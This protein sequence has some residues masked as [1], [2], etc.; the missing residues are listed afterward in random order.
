MDINVIRGL[1]TIFALFAFLCV[2]GWAYSSHRKNR[3]EDDGMIPFKENDDLYGK[4]AVEKMTDNKT[5]DKKP[6]DDK[7]SE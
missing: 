1:G 5:E 3:F 2:V 4:D 7:G 6:R